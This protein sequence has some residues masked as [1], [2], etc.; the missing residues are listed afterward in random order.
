MTAIV[1]ALSALMQAQDTP[2][3]P[4]E[5]VTATK[6]WSGENS[7]IDRAEY[8]RINEP[9]AWT[10]LWQR[11]VGKKER[12]PEV[13]FEKHMVVAA[14]LGRVAWEKIGLHAIKKTKDEI[15]FGLEVEDADCC[16]FSTHPLYLIAVVPRSDFKLAI[17]SRVRSGTDIDPRKDELLKEFGKVE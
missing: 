10:T 16:D 2:P 9:E 8:H 17:I 13:D 4:S 7:R 1:L 11:H 6:V 12:A 15:V 5:T 3:A 14:F